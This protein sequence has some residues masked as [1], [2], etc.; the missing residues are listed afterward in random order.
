VLVVVDVNSD[1]EFFNEATEFNGAIFDDWS[2][3]VFRVAN[4]FEL[5]TAVVDS[6]TFFTVSASVR[7]NDSDF[8][9][10]EAIG[11]LVSFFGF[12][13]GG[14]VANTRLATAAR[15]SRFK[16]SFVSV[17][18]WVS[19][20][21]WARLLIALASPD[22]ATFVGVIR[23]VSENFDFT[24]STC[25]T[26]WSF[27]AVFRNVFGTLDWFTPFFD[28][29]SSS[30]RTDSFDFE[31]SARNSFVTTFN[32]L[33]DDHAWVITS[34]SS[35]DAFIFLSAVV[36]VPEFTSSMFNSA[37]ISAN[38]AISWVNTFVALKNKSVLAEATLLDV[39]DHAPSF[40]KTIQL[41]V[42]A[43]FWSGWSASSPFFVRVFA[44]LSW[45]RQ[46]VVLSI[47]IVWNDVLVSPVVDTVSSVAR[48]LLSKVV[49]L[50]TTSVETFKNIK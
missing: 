46:V 43:S 34:T 16:K 13:T 1:W 21:K 27:W 14:S 12:S 23:V 8:F 35:F 3:A 4:T 22:W 5:W 9:T 25:D 29:T 17:T 45:A 37:F 42:I 49:D 50:F 40:V 32:E 30:I 7:N 36:L 31:F 39:F 19:V 47:R 41:I 48:T 18:D 2:S 11:F 10:G 28:A 26:N 20:V 6:G 38:V 15:V 24:E 33:F 44:S